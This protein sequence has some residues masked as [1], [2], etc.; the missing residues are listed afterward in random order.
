MIKVEHFILRLLLATTLA[1][2]LIPALTQQPVTAREQA[3]VVTIQAA[4]PKTPTVGRPYT[5]SVLVENDA[6]DQRIGLKDL[7][8]PGV[9]AVST[10]PSQGTCDIRV[11]DSGGGDSVRCDL[12]VVQGGST[13]E[14]EIVVIPRA[15][16]TMTNTAIATSEI[17]PATAANSSS[18]SVR[19]R[20]APVVGI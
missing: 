8:P 9:Q 1:A 20:P 5:F 15:P 6:V 4:T 7:L 2:S 18:A 13:A 14:V 17:T 12:G 10:T 3:G 19:V 11:G 16:G